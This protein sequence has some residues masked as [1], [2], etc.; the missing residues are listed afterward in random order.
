MQSL[1]C[2]APFAD[3]PP[4][5]ILVEASLGLQLGPYLTHPGPAEAA[6]DDGLFY[7]PK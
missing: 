7:G 4:G 3:L 5:W 2:P 6:K 1:G